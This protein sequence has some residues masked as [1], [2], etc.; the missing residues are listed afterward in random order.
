[1]KDYHALLAR[2][3]AMRLR[4]QLLSPAQPVTGPHAGHA[5]PDPHAYD[6]A[7]DQALIVR[8]LPAVAPLATLIDRLYHAMFTRHPYLRQLFPE[9][10]DFQR[11]HL[12]HAFRF[13]I[14]HLD[15]PAELAG[16]C[17]RLGSGH[18]RLG[19]LP[20]HYH[21]FEESLVE[22]L[23]ATA[24]EAWERETERAWVR[25]HRFVTGAM[26]DG[27]AGTARE[28][29]RW[30][31]TVVRHEL[32]APD[33]AVLRLHPCEPFHHRAGQ[34]VPVQSPLLPHTWRSYTLACAPAGDLE[35]HVRCVAAGGV[36]E[37]LVTRTAPGDELH[38]GR[39]DGDTV[40]DDD[41]DRDVLIVAGGTGWATARAL[42]E[43]LVRRRP[44]GRTVHLF[45]GARSAAGF[46]DDA[47][48]TRLEARAPWLRVTRVTDADG[49]DPLPAALLRHADLSDCTAYLSGPA[50]LVATTAALLRRAGVPDHR[51]RHDP[52]PVGPGP[53]APLGPPPVPDGP[54]ARGAA[55][56]APA[57]F[58]G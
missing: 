35:L 39:P 32:R 27:A 30:R 50:G 49:P 26:I 41:L 48:L 43:E 31:A 44:L 1:M 8:D 56:T 14:E 3:E 57:G 21:V 45:V 6:G 16:F 54:A 46:Y 33:L 47:A 13:A 20:A 36:S 37:A 23:R 4:Q 5:G 17:T 15:R 7:A 42:L 38:L 40:L 10:M 28:P 22:A 18:R 19:V 53:V 58:P 2:Q 12:E 51:I 34:Y 11:A 52:F 9:S 24:G 29:G 55:R 25:M